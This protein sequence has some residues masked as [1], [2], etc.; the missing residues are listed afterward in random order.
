MRIVGDRILTSERLELLIRPKG[1]SADG[2]RIH[3]LRER[4][5][6]DGLEWTR[7]CAG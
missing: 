4:D 3:R 7:P 5:L 2:V 6:E 1:V